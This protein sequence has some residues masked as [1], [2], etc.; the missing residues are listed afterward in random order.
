MN[1]IAILYIIDIYLNVKTILAILD[2]LCFIAGAIY[3]F[4]LFNDDYVAQEVK[5]H[6]AIFRT[7]IICF[8]IITLFLTLAPSI[9]FLHI[10]I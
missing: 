3:I 5:K 6:K 1:T 10:L 8:G 2:F 4:A 7:A 9:E